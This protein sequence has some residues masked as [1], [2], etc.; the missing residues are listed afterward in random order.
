[1]PNYDLKMQCVDPTDLNDS[2]SGGG[3]RRDTGSSCATAVVTSLEL[4]NPHEP[5]A[6][7]E[8][9]SQAVGEGEDRDVSIDSSDEAI[10]AMAD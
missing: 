8:G 3:L 9:N 1:M 6:L 2:S 10:L 7:A 4:A 5:A